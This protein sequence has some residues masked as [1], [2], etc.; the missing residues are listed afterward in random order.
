MDRAAYVA[1]V[2]NFDINHVSD[3]RKELSFGDTNGMTSVGLL[4]IMEANG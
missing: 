4:W 3:L 1:A 2:S